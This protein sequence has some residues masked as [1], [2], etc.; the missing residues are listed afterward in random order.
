[1]T[2]TLSLDP[3]DPVGEEAP[4]IEARV[5]IGMLLREGLRASL[6][7]RPRLGE[8]TVRPLELVF[9]I[10][11]LSLIELAAGRLQVVGQARF[12]FSVWLFQWW[13]V[14]ATVLVAWIV[15]PRR[16][17]VVPTYFGLSTV[18]CAPAVLVLCAMGIANVHGVMS[19][20][21]TNPWV[22]WPLYIGL[23]AWMTAISLAL[24]W[25]FG[26]RTLA[27]IA[28]G[29]CLGALQAISYRQDVGPAF[30]AVQTEP[31]NSGPRFV[32]SQEVFEKQ[33]ALFDRA[34]TGLAPQRGGVQD[35]YGLVFAPYAEEDVFRRESAMVTRVIESRFDAEGR[36]IQLVNNAA[37]TATLPWATPVNLQRAVDAIARTMD[38]ENDLL[39]VY[40]TS[41]GARNRK[42]AAEHWPLEVDEVTPEMLRASLDGA[43][44][45]HRVI[46]VSAC[47]SGGWIP[48]LEG[49]DTLVMTA[50]DAD[51]TSYGC[52]RGSELTFFGRALFDEQLR[53][54]RSF[55]DA[56]AA[57]VPVI[58]Q[59][60]DEA[61]KS[62]GF[63]NPQISMGPR[64]KAYLDQLR[65]RLDRAAQ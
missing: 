40:L 29:V 56:F 38:R 19:Q 32:L 58:R 1:M 21:L 17:G 53:G 25:H 10:A 6:F 65:G 35:V 44:I 62:D 20:A 18:A 26:A 3:A 9:V 23:L 15:L 55:E 12:L 30:R 60:E 14:A 50:A 31:E 27:V 64:I 46:A 11:A 49:D 52:G 16:V 36:V 24:A 7:L 48:S 47:Y 59:R 13:S 34:V 45:R 4:R 54:T 63:S 5:P 28:F 37:T 57:A 22:A 8:R 61:G 51:H 2:S 41:H 42:L 39:V 33:Q 43:G